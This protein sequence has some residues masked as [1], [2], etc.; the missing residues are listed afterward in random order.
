MLQRMFHPR[1]GRVYY[2]WV[3]LV[4]VSITEVVS[5]GILYYAFTVFIAPMQAEL[6]WSREALTGGYSLALLC[7]GIAAVPVGWWLDR[8]GP[9]WLM[10]AGSCLASCL[11]LAWS[12][13]AIVGPVLVNYIRQGQISAGVPAAQAYSVTMYIMAGLLLV[14]LVCNLM[15]REVDARYHHEEKAAAPSARAAPSGARRKP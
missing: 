15:V 8:H 6:G 7:S 14:G 9:R 4:A 3:L 5:W 12:L 2:G 10:T 1:H 13:A 11:L